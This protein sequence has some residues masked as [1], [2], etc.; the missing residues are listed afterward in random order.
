MCSNISYQAQYIYTQLVWL[1]F[2]Y[3]ETIIDQ[4]IS[5]KLDSVSQTNLYKDLYKEG[6]AGVHFQE[7]PT[8]PAP[9]PQLGI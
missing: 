7:W 8:S 6:V 5:E 9:A 3:L 1:S 4:M 2:S